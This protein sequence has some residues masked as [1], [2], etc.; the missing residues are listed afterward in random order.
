[1]CNINSSDLLIPCFYCC[2]SESMAEGRYEAF[3]SRLFWSAKR[4]FRRNFLISLRQIQN[5]KFPRHYSLS[6][7]GGIYYSARRS[8]RD[9]SVCAYVRRIVSRNFVSTVASPV[10]ES[11][12]KIKS[13]VFIA[14]PNNMPLDYICGFSALLNIG[15]GRVEGK[16]NEN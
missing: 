16:V 6:L 1:M 2:I 15:R 14:N 3:A 9:V 10:S 8:S 12:H 13:V 5:F 4:V 11:S 7:A